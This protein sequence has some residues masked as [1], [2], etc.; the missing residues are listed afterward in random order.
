MA[1]GRSGWRQSSHAAAPAQIAAAIHI[2]VRRYRGKPVTPSNVRYSDDLGPGILAEHTGQLP[3][4]V[5]PG[6]PMAAAMAESLARSA[7]QSGDRDQAGDHRRPERHEYTSVFV[8]L[9]WTME[10]PLVAL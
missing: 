10:A 2:C 7:R 8:V 9:E 1:P 5:F 4:D 3:A 6:Q